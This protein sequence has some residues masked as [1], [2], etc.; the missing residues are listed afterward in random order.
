MR[1]SAYLLGHYFAELA[2][3]VLSIVVLLTA[4]LIVGWRPHTS[5]LDFAQAILL[6]IAFSSGI[7]WVGM[8]LGMLVRSP[9]AVMGVGFIAVFPLT[10]LSNAF[11]PIGS[12]T[13]VLQWFASL[14]PVSVL[15]AAVRTLFGNPVAP[16]TKHVWP[17][18]HPVAAA[19]LY[20]AILIGVAV[21]AATRRYRVR[22]SD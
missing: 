21:V 9:D 13:N 11:V 2:G 1:K 19:W 18:D 10:F 7:I 14:N 12:L 4:G 6:L 17:M 5:L 22:T 3:L 20:T 8:F 16:V 15:V